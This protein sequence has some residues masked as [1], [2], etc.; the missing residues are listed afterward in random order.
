MLPSRSLATLG[1]DPAL[2]RHF[3]APQS[4]QLR[5]ASTKSV[6]VFLLAC[7]ATVNDDTLHGSEYIP[8]IH[9]KPPQRAHGAVVL[10]EHAFPAFFLCFRPL[11]CADISLA[12]TAHRISNHPT[13]HGSGRHRRSEYLVE[14]ADEAGPAVTGPILCLGDAPAQ[15]EAPYLALGALIGPP[16]LR[17]PGAM[18]LGQR[19]AS[20]VVLAAFGPLTLGA[21]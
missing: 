12:I 6:E 10:D 7:G 3:H 8:R 5:K 11:C 18:W 19:D 16:V 4:S 21:R 2:C 1:A 14:L 15:A 17:Q 13:E 9:P 20:N